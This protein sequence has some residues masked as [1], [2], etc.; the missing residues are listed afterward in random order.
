MIEYARLSTD[1]YTS[2]VHVYCDLDGWTTHVARGRYILIEEL[3]PRVP[4]PDD[5]TPQELERFARL[6]V[7]R[8]RAVRHAIDTALLADIGG[9]HDGELYTD[10]TPAACAD[11]LEALRAA[12]YRVP[13]SA[14]DVLGVEAA[15]G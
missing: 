13:Q 9:D 15:G 6:I 5:P 11:R 4:V 14:L 2:D 8:E 7:D 3:P 10:P 1:D 12:G